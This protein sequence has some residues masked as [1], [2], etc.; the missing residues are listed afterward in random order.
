MKKYT[1]TLFSSDEILANAEAAKKENITTITR[2]VEVLEYMDLCLARALEFNDC[3]RLAMYN[4]WSERLDEVLPNF[5]G[6]IHVPNH[7][8]YLLPT[9]SKPTRRNVKRAI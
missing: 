4:V 3:R 2:L 5:K 8:E 1:R 9:L 6:H 7:L